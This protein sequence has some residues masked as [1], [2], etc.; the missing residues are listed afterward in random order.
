M[1]ME[2]YLE[3]TRSMELLHALAGFHIPLQDLL[4]FGTL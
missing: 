1:E 4:I 2:Q 3:Y